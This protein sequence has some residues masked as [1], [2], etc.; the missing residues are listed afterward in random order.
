MNVETSLYH[1]YDPYHHCWTLKAVAI[2]SGIKV[3]RISKDRKDSKY[4]WLKIPGTVDRCFISS[5]MNMCIFRQSSKS[6]IKVVDI[7]CILAITNH[8]SESRCICTLHF[9][10]RKTYFWLCK[11]LK[12]KRLY[13]VHINTSQ[14]KQTVAEVSRGNTMV[15]MVSSLVTEVTLW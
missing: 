1:A 8:Y 12:T 6:T 3:H 5:S 9:S 15:T 13:E 4:V 11:H 10:V 2:S 7:F 14:W